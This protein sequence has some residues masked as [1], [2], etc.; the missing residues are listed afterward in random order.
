MKSPQRASKRSQLVSSGQINMGPQL[1]GKLAVITGAATGIGRAAGRLFAQE[2]AAVVIGDVN[3]DEGVKFAQA[4]RDEGYQAWYQ[5]VDVGQAT[6]MES[7]IHEASA[8]LGGIDI[9][10][11]NAGAQRSGRVTEFDAEEWDL[12]MRINARS[13]FLSAKYAVPHLRKRGA[14]SIINTASTAGLKG[15][16]GMTAYSASKGAI[17]AFSRALAVEVASDGIRVNCICPGWVDTRFNAPAI[18]FMGG[19]EEHRLSFAPPFPC[20]DRGHPKRLPPSCCSWP[21]THPCT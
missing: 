3:D 13:S 7:F 5:H 1:E 4:L 20:S 8:L 18:R 17:I 10:V 11:N 6:E 15:G 12:L 14:G 9:V 21:R 2:R 19:R 16:P